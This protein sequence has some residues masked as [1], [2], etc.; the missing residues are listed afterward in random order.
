MATKKKVKS[1]TNTEEKI[2]AAARKVFMLKGFSGT[3]TRDI[4]E[5]AG[6]NLA[7][8]NYYF[9]SKKKLF[10]LI[11]Q[12]KIQNLFG[13]IA[14]VLT[15]SSTTLETK[16]N[17]IV[18]GYIDVLSENPDLPTFVLNELRKKNFD[19]IQKFPFDKVIVQSSFIKQLKERRSDINPVHFL[20]NILGMTV[21]PF[22][23]KP[24]LML[25]AHCYHYLEY[26]LAAIP[27]INY[28]RTQ[29]LYAG[30]M[31]SGF[32][33]ANKKDTISPHSSTMVLGIYTQ[34]KSWMAGAIQQLYLKEDKWRIKAGAIKGNINFQFFN[35]DSYTN[36]GEYED[37][38]SDMV[39]ALGQVQRKIWRRLYGGILGEY[40][41]TTTY[42]TSEGDSSDKQNMSNIGYVFSQDSRDNVQFPTTGIFLNFKNQFYREWTGSTSDFVRYKINY[43]QFFNLLKDE[44]HI[45]VARFNA[46][47]AT[48]NVPFSGQA[49]VGMDDIRGYSQG[50]FRGNQV[51]DVQSEYRWMFNNSNFGMVGFFGVAS[52][53]ETA[54]DIFK[55]A[56]LPGG[57]VGIRYRIIPSLKVNIGVDVGVGKD[58]YSLTFRIGEAF[59]R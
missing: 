5:E 53:V 43:T 31:V 29:G 24:M 2:I 21:F 14:P 30:G 54:S 41:I 22:V 42:F 35:G 13:I 4:A 25:S 15:D 48:G 34:E 27:I 46:E 50:Q 23:A 58:D 12:E 33:R 59:G 16:I 11:M 8:L 37:Y 56:L 3:R 51:Y 36:V 40:N 28:N 1:E 19:I 52:A 55:T 6:I 45:L 38:T 44:R 18:S 47:I 32:Y 39:I 49:I 7:L 26:R 10:D 9:R 17:L 20:I 57:G